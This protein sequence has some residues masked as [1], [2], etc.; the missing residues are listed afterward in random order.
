MCVLKKWL[1]THGYCRE[2]WGDIVRMS[3]RAAV[4]HPAGTPISSKNVGDIV[5]ITVNNKIQEFIIVHKGRP[6]TLYDTSFNNAVTVLEKDTFMSARWDDSADKNDY[7]KSTIHAYLNAD[8]FYYVV[9]SVRDQIKQIKI[10]YR[11][12]DGNSLTVYSEAIG[13]PAKVF[14]LSMLEVGFNSSSTV[15]ADGTVLSYFQGTSS[16]GADPKRIAK[17]ANG[18]AVSW[19]LRTPHAS[20]PGTAA[21]LVR[22]TGENIALA[23]YG[24]GSQGIRPAFVLPDTTNIADD[25][26][27]L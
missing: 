24:G 9:Q 12:G 19:W 25:G 17:S 18:S 5:K 3:R 6:S 15:P 7:E 20:T 23:T 22:H 10:P 4:C 21:F 27:V 8:F 16:T 26:T 1:L 2:T 11:R 14:L 13:L